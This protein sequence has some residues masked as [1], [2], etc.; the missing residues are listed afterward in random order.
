MPP[1]IIYL[2]RG[3]PQRPRANLIQTLHTVAAL[4]QA[5][6]TVRLYLPPIPRRFDL[7]GFLA[8]MGLRTP[9]DVRGS[10]LL[11]SNW[12]GW[13]FMLAH[14]RELRRA[15]A[16]YT[17]VPDFSR[18]MTRLRIGHVL[19]IH[20]T[21]A[22]LADGGRWLR[23]AMRAGW[24]RGLT[25]I[26]GAGRDALVGAGLPATR[27]EVLHSGVDLTAFASVPAPTPEA[28]AEAHGLYVGRISR[29]RGLPML[30][31][32]ARAGLP[33]TLI[34]PADDPP[35]TDLPHLTCRP[36][37]PHAQVPDA[38]AAGAIAL[39]PYQADLQHAAT[40]SPIKLFEA[41]AAGRL[42]IASD[43]PTIRE[44]IRD[45]D[46]GLLVPADDPAAWIAAVMRVRAHPDDA[47]RMAAAGRRTAADFS[48]PARAGRLLAFLDRMQSR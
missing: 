27:I 43:L 24:L 8:G 31:A 21:V 17:R 42:V 10:A 14:R 36:A 20:D 46:N 25:V 9:V 33:V 28:F 48:W 45:G 37:I 3:R 38:L 41:M 7:T 22:L 40:I 47:A 2:A 34:G 1:H 23:E 32:V 29:D 4:G 35:A 11:H 5:G 44:V 12:G 26:S 16:V 6:A 39:M 15:D 30:E 18:L 13:P 19:E